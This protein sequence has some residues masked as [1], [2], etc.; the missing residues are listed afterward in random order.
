M[1]INQEKTKKG[2]IEDGLE[3]LGYKF[4]GDIITIRQSSILK[5]ERNIEKIFKNFSLIQQKDEKQIKQ[6]ESIIYILL[7]KK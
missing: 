7:T 5:F 4:E 1:L 3:Y 6:V 2:N